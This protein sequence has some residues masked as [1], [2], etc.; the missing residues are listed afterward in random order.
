[1][2]FF[3]ENFPTKD[4]TYSCFLH[5]DSKKVILII[6]LLMFFSRKNGNTLK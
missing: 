3:I 4:C 6:I 2:Y 1:M 5:K